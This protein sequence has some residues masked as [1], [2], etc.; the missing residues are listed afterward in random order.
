VSAAAISVE[1]LGKAYTVGRL[2]RHQTLRDL[3]GA[4]VRP[5]QWGRTGEDRTFWALSDVSFEVAAG[6]V[7]ALV[8]PNGAG[9]STLLKLLSRIVH[10][11]TGTIELRGRVGSLLEV[12][13]GFHPDLTGRENVFLNG[14]ILGMSRT[15]VRSRLDSIVAFAELERF[16]DTPVK[17]YSSGMYMRLAF[18]VAAHLDPEILLVDEVLAVGDASFQKKCLGRVSEIAHA[19]R[20]V[21]FVTHDMTAVDALCTRALLLKHGRVELD[22]SAGDVITQYLA[23]AVPSDAAVVSLADHP[24]RRGRTAAIM[25]SAVLTG[26][27]GQ[28]AAA[29]PM[30]SDLE[31]RVQFESDDGPVRPYMS[32]VVKTSRGLPVFGNTNRLA[33]PDRF[34]PQTSGVI[35]CRI[36][37]LPL[38]PGRYH[39]DLYFEGSF[40]IL[41]Q[42]QEALTFDVV[43]ADVFGTGYLPPAQNGP[44]AWPVTYEL[45]DRLV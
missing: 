12:G 36:P 1:R 8:G 14:A 18:A 21:V 40:E 15:E 27:D 3:V 33:D 29:V 41:E 2:G 7:V 4:A 31:I 45:H 39:V 20:T 32:A 5:S 26:P 43:P 44:I 19:G 17:K 25:R 23:G 6:E 42:I 30:G 24:H 13:T 28:P 22:G 34:A 9:K 16:I 35:A 11:T 10:P 38:M 37:Q